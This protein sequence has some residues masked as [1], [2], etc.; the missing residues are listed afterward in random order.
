LTLLVWKSEREAG[1][2]MSRQE[3]PE[4]PLLWSLKTFGRFVLQKCRSAGPERLD[5][6]EMEMERAGRGLKISRT[7]LRSIFYFQT[8]AGIGGG[9]G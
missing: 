2:L 4:M 3:L 8:A 6:E 9:V 5:S 1:V 7:A